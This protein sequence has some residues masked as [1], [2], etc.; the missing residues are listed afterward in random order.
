VIEHPDLGII[1]SYARSERTK[2]QLIIRTKA[3]VSIDENAVIGSI[4]KGTTLRLEITY[5]G[6]PV[7]PRYIPFTYRIETFGFRHGENEAIK[8]D[9]KSYNYNLIA[10]FLED[11][12]KAETID[13]NTILK[14]L[15]GKEE[16][17]L[18][19]DKKQSEKKSD[20]AE[21]LYSKIET[22][23]IN[24]NPEKYR[25]IVEFE[26]A[27]VEFQHTNSKTFRKIWTMLK[28]L[29]IGLLGYYTNEGGVDTGKTTGLIFTFKSSAHKLLF[30]LVGKRTLELSNEDVFSYL[31]ARLELEMEKQ[32]VMRRILLDYL[33]FAAAEMVLRQIIKY[34]L[35][36]EFQIA[37]E[38]F[39]Q[40]QND[41]LEAIRMK[42][43]KDKLYILGIDSPAEFRS[44]LDNPQQ[45]FNLYKNTMAYQKSLL[46]RGQDS[47]FWQKIICG[48]VEDKFLKR[49]FVNLGITAEFQNIANSTVTPTVGIDYK[50]IDTLSKK[51]KILVREFINF[52]NQ[53][54]LIVKEQEHEFIQ[55]VNRLKERQNSI[56]ENLASILQKAP[57]MDKT[58][59]PQLQQETKLTP[60]TQSQQDQPSQLP[61]EF[62]KVFP[63]SKKTPEILQR[64]IREILL[65]RSDENSREEGVVK[66]ILSRLFNNEEKKDRQLKDELIQLFSDLIRYQQTNTLSEEQFNV[67]YK[68]VEK[69]N[70]ALQVFLTSQQGQV[71]DF[72]QVNSLEELL[73]KNTNKPPILNEEVAFRELLELALR[74][75]DEVNIPEVVSKLLAVRQVVQSISK[76]RIEKQRDLEQRMT[77]VVT[78]AVKERE[79]P[80]KKSIPL[81]MPTTPSVSQVPAEVEKLRRYFAFSAENNIFEQEVEKTKKVLE[82]INN[83]S[84]EAAVLRLQQI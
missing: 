44:L 17:I 4:A 40:Q 15:F 61:K 30:S 19:A 12:K 66:K 67:A 51:N 35:P 68:E 59:L 58:K 42:T 81:S 80:N 57:L 13:L 83:H 54:T 14:Q 21:P 9:H 47:T 33:E 64:K 37:Y 79:K 27:L 18:S 20:K 72:E 74:L 3:G 49:M 84:S 11:L 1:S 34:D 70:R 75:N 7:N 10:Q 77:K 65:I 41:F 2:G 39:V 76:V 48:V 8:S 45:L 56:F 82:F 62:S 63:D 24:N 32:A 50:F 53:Q 6:I 46:S 5:Q 28:E 23:I 43:R 52:I 78:D 36:E 22:E 60:N 55:Q 31:S 25:H 16:T 69:N 26:K 71:S 38:E 73:S 29:N